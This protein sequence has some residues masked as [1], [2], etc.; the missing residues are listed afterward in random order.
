MKML[1]AVTIEFDSYDELFALFQARQLY[2]LS[3]KRKISTRQKL[4]LNRRFA[5]GYRLIRGNPKYAEMYKKLIQFSR[6]VELT[7]IPVRK[8]DYFGSRVIDFFK[9][10]IYF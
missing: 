8:E 6:F 4:E 10:I 1:K 5:K 7:G 2:A 3:G 9:F